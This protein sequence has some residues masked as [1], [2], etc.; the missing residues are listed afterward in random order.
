MGSYTIFR[1]MNLMHAFFDGDYVPLLLK[2]TH[3]KQV[4]LQILHVMNI[5]R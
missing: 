5:K 4:I 1:I 2:L 3:T